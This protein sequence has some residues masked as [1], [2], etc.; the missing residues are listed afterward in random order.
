MPDAGLHLQGV[1]L[2]R[3]RSEETS[4]VI[5]LDLDSILCV[6]EHPDGTT[7]VMTLR[8]ANERYQV[9]SPINRL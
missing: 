4:A 7:E 6:V 8:E 3:V 5:E 2:D 9:A 1:R